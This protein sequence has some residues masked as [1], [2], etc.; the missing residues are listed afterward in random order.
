MTAECE[1][2]KLQKKVAELEIERD[3]CHLVEERQSNKTGELSGNLDSTDGLKGN[4]TGITSL[5]LYNP[6]QYNYFFSI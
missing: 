4:E 2:D 6:F 1:I 3:R 5:I